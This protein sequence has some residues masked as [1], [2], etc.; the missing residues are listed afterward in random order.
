MKVPAIHAIGP[1]C[2]TSPSGF[3]FWGLEHLPRD[4]GQPAEDHRRLVSSVLQDAWCGDGMTNEYQLDPAV[5]GPA[6]VIVDLG[7]NVGSFALGAAAAIPGALI[8]AVEPSLQSYGCL[9]ANVLEAAVQNRVVP[10]RYAVAGSN[11]RCVLIENLTGT[12]RQ[13]WEEYRALD[14][15]YV[16]DGIVGAQG[17]T[18]EALLSEYEIERVDFLKV[19][20]EGSEVDAFLATPPEVMRR[21]GLIAMEIHGKPGQDAMAAH[22]AKTHKVRIPGHLFAELREEP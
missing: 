3:R 17:R 16:F 4:P 12:C 7:A 6:P 18:I 15:A 5:L 9:V 8:L 20:I 22:I 21:I 11:A 10:A 1:V 13:S 14:P 2:I 19:D